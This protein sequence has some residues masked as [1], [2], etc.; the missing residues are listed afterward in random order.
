LESIT[1]LQLAL[2]DI[3]GTLRRVRSPW[4]HIHEHLGVAEQAERYVELWHKGE[5]TYAEWADLDASLWR[6]AARETMVAALETDPYRMGARELVRWFTDRDI[7]CLG[8]ST[9]LSLF[10]DVTARELG[11][12]EVITNE[13]HFQDGLCT[14]RVTVRVREDNKAAIALALL[15]RYGVDAVHVVAFGD[16]TAD[17]PVMQAVGLGI[18][19]C[20]SNERV[21]AGAHRVVDAEPIDRAVAIIEQSIVAQGADSW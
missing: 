20:P 3:D 13:V 2:F 7:P 17:I 21:R 1:S 15:E 11:L 16:G 18:A 4:T 9:G 14:G 8:I 10:N 6:G 12:R 19:I 5:I